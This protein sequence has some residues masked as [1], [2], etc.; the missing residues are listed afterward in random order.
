MEL[1]VSVHT[2]RSWEQG[3]NPIPRLVEKHLLSET[4]LL[5]PLD[6][7]GQINQVAARDDVSFQEALVRTLKKGLLVED[8]PTQSPK[9]KRT[10]ASGK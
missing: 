4:D 2:I 5:V 9:K 8:G 1:K 10:A 3:K 6:L 7:I